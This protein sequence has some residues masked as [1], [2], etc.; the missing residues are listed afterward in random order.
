MLVKEPPHGDVRGADLS[1]EKH[2]AEDH[3][4]VHEVQGLLKGHHSDDVMG[5]G[6][7]VE[8]AGPLTLHSLYIQINEEVGT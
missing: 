8:R 7:V 5:I 3:L 1:E 6:L 4:V 2:D